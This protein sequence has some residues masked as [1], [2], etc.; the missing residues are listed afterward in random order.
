MFAEIGPEGWVIIIGALCTGVGGIVI[1]LYGMYLSSKR[2]ESVKQEIKDSAKEVKEATVDAT[3]QTA[4]KVEEM[5][6]R[7]AEMKAKS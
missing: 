7:V 1:Q 3:Q 5:S 2:A 6:V 4:A